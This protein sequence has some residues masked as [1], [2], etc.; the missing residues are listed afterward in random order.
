VALWKGVTTNG[1]RMDGWGENVLKRGQIG[2]G[3]TVEGGDDGT[4]GW[5][6]N[7]IKGGQ[8]GAGGRWVV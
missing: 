1:R 8:I 3:G 5:G 6:E 4:D 7:V 2:A